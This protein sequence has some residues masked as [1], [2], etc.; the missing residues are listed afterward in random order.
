MTSAM[1][2]FSSQVSGRGEF[3]EVD[4]RQ[5]KGWLER[6]EAAL[7]DVREPDEFAREHIAGA[8]LLPLGTLDVG[9]AARA[10]PG[11]GR[12]VVHCKGGTRSGQAGA[13]LAGSGMPNVYSLKGGIEAWKAAGL[14]TE[15]TRGVPISVMRQVQI[16]VG[17]LVL[18][19]SVLA[20]LVSPW[21]LGLTAFF[22]AGLLFAGTTGMCGLAMVLGAM[23]WNR[24]FRA[25]RSEGSCC[26][27]A[28]SK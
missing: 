15:V 21:F 28:C 9:S 13:M 8:R 7:I 2:S 18:I 19:G 23:P 5:L 22:G 11:N 17:S 6:G 27:G 3:G 1:A 25:V 16:V 10:V 12:L 26:G 24:A 14:P 20:W 4:P